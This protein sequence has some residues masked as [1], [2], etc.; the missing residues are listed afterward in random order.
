V[1]D[2]SLCGH[3]WPLTSTGRAGHVW[4]SET[5]M[6]RGG[7][8]AREASVWS[9]IGELRPVSRGRVQLNRF[10]WPL[11]RR[12]SDPQIDRNTGSGP[13]RRGREPLFSVCVP[14]I[15]ASN[16]GDNA[17][18]MPALQAG[19]RGFEPPWLHFRKE[20]PRLGFDAPPGLLLWPRF[21]PPKRVQPNKRKEGGFGDEPHRLTGTPG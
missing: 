8:M 10:V 9:V 17:A 19:G 2:V 12:D 6:G 20:L 13:L 15:T 21:P 3:H 7:G 14:G 4:A 11:P 1:S 16:D 5:E 18:L